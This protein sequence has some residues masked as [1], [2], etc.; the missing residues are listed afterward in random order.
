M[1]FLPAASSMSNEYI[2]LLSLIFTG[3]SLKMANSVSLGSF[4]PNAYLNSSNTS[5][6]GHEQDIFH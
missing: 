5:W 6:T 4:T 1:A 3:N 2:F